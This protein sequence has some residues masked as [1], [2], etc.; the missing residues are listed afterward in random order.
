[1]QLTFRTVEQQQP[2]E[3]IRK[4]LE[5]LFV[6]SFSKAYREIQVNLP[7]N[8]S[9]DEWLRDTFRELLEKSLTWL[10]CYSKGD[11]IAFLT[12]EKKFERSYY[13]NQ[14]VVRPDYQRTSV[15][16]RT[17]H[18]L[19]AD[20]SKVANRQPIYLFGYVRSA[21]LPAQHFYRSLGASIK[22]ITKNDGS[23][24]HPDYRL[25]EYNGS[26]DSIIA[27]SGK[28]SSRL[29]VVAFLPVNSEPQK[30]EQKKKKKKNKKN[31]KRG[32][33]A[34]PTTA[35]ATP[36]APAPTTSLP[37][38]L[39]VPPATIPQPL[40]LPVQTPQAPTPTAG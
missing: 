2:E 16:T 29:L 36:S 5:D 35:T 9:R 13:V 8:K 17:V 25:V 6:D 31:K 39:Q 24:T 23:Y 18:K 22:Q 7:K 15:G 21:N 19:I 10:L 4:E 34:A 20:L 11:V 12:V 26:L 32:K 33:K 14:L 37:A 3:A 27:R 1:L 40:V 28:N 38:A 30:L